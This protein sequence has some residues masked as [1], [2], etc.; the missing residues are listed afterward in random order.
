MSEESKLADGSP[1]G[2]VEKMLAMGDG[3]GAAPEGDGVIGSQ[4]TR[5]ENVPEKFW[6]AEKGAINTDALLKSQ[7]DAEA[8]LRKGEPAPKEE[9]KADEKEPEGTPEQVDVVA[10]ASAEWTEKGELSEDTFKSLE[11]AGISRDMV[12][13]YIAGQQAVVSNLESAV[14]GPFD[15]AEGY[16]KAAQW[17][18]D[19]LSDSE[20]QA[21]DVQLTS[22]NPAIAAQGAL[23]LKKRFD[24]EADVEPSTI[25]GNSNTPA[26]GGSYMSSREM[27]KDM[28][29][30]EYRTSQ[31]FRDQVAQKLSRSN[32]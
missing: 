5:P 30:R 11:A 20:I 2:H 1:E 10:N 24:A 28:N 3:T 31:A 16:G 17:A 9:P 32:L 6:D 13:D 15:G 4:V 12:N 23:A 7:A 27:M 18:A 29:S 19:N 26:A 21:L 22:P 8:A 14:F 25:R